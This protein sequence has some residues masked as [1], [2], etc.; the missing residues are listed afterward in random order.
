MSVGTLLVTLWAHSLLGC[1]TR[2]RVAQC[3]LGFLFLICIWMHRINDQIPEIKRGNSWGKPAS[4]EII[5]DDIE[6][7][8]THAFLLHIEHIGTNVWLPNTHSVRPKVDFASSTSP[9]KSE[10]WKQSQSALLCG[11][12]HNNVVCIHSCDE[13]MRSNVLDVC[14]KLWSTSWWHVQVCWLTIK[15]QVYKCV[16]NVNM[17]G[18][19]ERKHLTILLLL[20][21][22]LFLNCWSSMH[23][24]DTL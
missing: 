2:H 21:I 6:L 22:L 20:S 12:P 9:E 19:F 14:R 17:I 24:V 23:G 8:Y 10:S 1:S 18:P 11:F 7:C 5:S 3:L 4:R 16:P 15:Y 13:C